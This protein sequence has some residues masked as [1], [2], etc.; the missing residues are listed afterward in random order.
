MTKWDGIALLLSN[1]W[2]LRP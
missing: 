1:K 2:L